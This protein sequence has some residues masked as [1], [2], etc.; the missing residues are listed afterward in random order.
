MT[1]GVLVW[2]KAWNT[3]SIP[4]LFRKPEHMQTQDKWKLE[5]WATTIICSYKVEVHSKWNRTLSRGRN[6]PSLIYFHKANRWLYQIH[7]LI[8]F[9]LRESWAETRKWLSIVRD[10]NIPQKTKH[11]WHNLCFSFIILICCNISWGMIKR[12]RDY[13]FFF[14]LRGLMSTTTPSWSRDAIAFY[15]CCKIQDRRTLF[16]TCSKGKLDTPTREFVNGDDESGSFFWKYIRWQGKVWGFKV[17]EP[18][19]LYSWHKDCM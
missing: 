2:I 15:Q 17:R 10:S 8:Y 7:F 4:K 18:P 11:V 5:M 14:P 19:Q 6:A 3:T 9:N 1:E 12:F 16:V 13:A